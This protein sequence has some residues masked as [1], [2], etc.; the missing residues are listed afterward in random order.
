MMGALALMEPSTGRFCNYLFAKVTVLVSAFGDRDALHA[1][2]VT[3]RVHHDEHVSEAAGFPG[4][5]CNRTAPP[6]SLK[7]GGGLASD[8]HLVFDADAVQYR[9]GA[10]SV[11]AHHEL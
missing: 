5:R 8:A 1:D 4:R 2:G 6:L 9:C 7:N 3:R 11:L 10:P